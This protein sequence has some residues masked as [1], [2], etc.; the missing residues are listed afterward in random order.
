MLPR[1]PVPCPKQ[2]N[3]Y[4]PRHHY[5]HL[6]QALYLPTYRYARRSPDRD[7]IIHISSFATS[8][9]ATS[10]S[11]RLITVAHFTPPR[12]RKARISKHFDSRSARSAPCVRLCCCRALPPCSSGRASLRNHIHQSTSWAD[13]RFEG[14]A[15]NRA[16]SAKNSLV[17]T[18][19]LRKTRAMILERSLLSSAAPSGARGLFAATWIR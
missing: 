8:Q 3:T 6:C 14:S 16:F 17:S 13:A 19:A 4:L 2:A 9:P 15:E 18:M 5:R 1:C 11:R 10:P 12:R 7:A